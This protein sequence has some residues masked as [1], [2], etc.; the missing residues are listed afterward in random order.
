MRRTVLVAALFAAALPAAAVADT[1]TALPGAP[2]SVRVGQRGQLQAFRSGSDSGIFYAPNEQAG[3]AGFFLALP[4]GYTGDTT[5]RVFGFTGTTGP[6]GLDEYKLGTQLPPTGA[7]TV[8]DPFQQLTSYAVSNESETKE[9]LQVTQYTLCVAGSQQFSVIWEVHNATA[10]AINFKAIAAADFYFDGSDRGTGIYTDGPPRFIGGTNAD[11][12]ASGGF[13]EATGSGLQPWSAYQA[14]E[15]G[16]LPEQV[17]GK[18]QGAASTS[19]PTFDDTVIGESVDDAGGVEWDQDASGA[20]LPA[21]ATR[22]FELS[23]RS[24]VP[25]AMQIL[26]SNGGAPRGVP[27]DFK[28]IAT[29]SDGVPY[30]GRTLR[31]QINGANPEAGSVTL[32]ANGQ[33]AI[34]DSGTNA[35][36]DTVVAFVDFNNDGTREPAEPQASALGTFVD[37]VPPSCKVKV[38]GDRVGGGGAGKPLRITVSC[39][40]S[41]TVTAATTL[42]TIPTAGRASVSKKAKPVKIK[43]KP[44]S[45]TVAPGK[46]FPVKI[47]VPRK[48]LRKYAGKTLRASIKVTARD[49]SQN[50]KSVTATSKVHILA[51]TKKAKRG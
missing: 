16:P 2:L 51:K 33:G 35:G 29:N 22:R 31:Y 45:A 6:D 34:V 41:A 24:A 19:G 28:A 15:F 44:T 7:G 17:W 3:D 30:A 38:T 4:S 43:L 11:S 5:P 46:A 49:S 18:V 42:L 50:V 27:I 47:V 1:T 9:I 37:N 26:P 39:D 8:A 10:S 40:E 13:L 32:D 25:A 23:I 21:G 20:G 12:G 36:A 14:L 48:V